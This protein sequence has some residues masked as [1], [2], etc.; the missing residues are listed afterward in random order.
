[1]RLA[2]DTIADRMY[3]SCNRQCPFPLSIHKAI[4]LL[5]QADTLQMVTVDSVYREIRRLLRRTFLSDR[6]ARRM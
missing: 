4:R 6:Y 3:A 2:I 5:P 1:M